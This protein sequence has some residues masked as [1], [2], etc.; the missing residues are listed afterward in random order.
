M[1]RIGS[2]RQR[3]AASILFFSLVPIFTVNQYRF[4]IGNHS[5]VVP[6][7]QTMLDPGLFPGDYL[8]AERGHL[9]TYFWPA[10]AFLIGHLQVS[11][12][13]L[14][15]AL[16]CAATVGAV[17]GVHR[18]AMRLFGR[19]DVAALSMFFFM[20]SFP[21]LG[22]RS[23]F[24][25][26]LD[27]VLVACPF[28]LFA[29][30]AMLARRHV[31]AFGLLGVAFLI[32]PLSAIY[33]TGVV[34]AASI[35]DLRTVGLARLAAALGLMTV[36]MLPSLVWRASGA[37]TSLHLLHAD[38]SWLDLLRLRSPYHIFPSTW[39]VGQF[40]GAALLV[41][42]FVIGWK[43]RPDAR[44]HRLVAAATLG[45]FAMWTAGTVFVEMLP[46]AIVVQAQL[47]RSS[48]L[49]LTLA[50]IYCANFFFR[51]LEGDASAWRR[52]LAAVPAVGVLYGARGGLVA[53]A[54]LIGFAAAVTFL[55][56]RRGVRVEAGRTVPLLMVLSLGLGVGAYG[57]SGGF[58]IYDADTPAWVDVQH[59]ARTHSERADLFIVPVQAGASGFR[60]ESERSIYVDWKDG[61]EMFWNPAFGDEWHRRMLSVGFRDGDAMDDRAWRDRFLTLDESAFRAIA[62]ATGGPDRRTM[63]VMFTE[64]APLAFPV[65][66]RNDAFVV[67]DVR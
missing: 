59:W 19:E 25:N 62:R 14:F 45:I 23:V 55:R 66:F 67:Y 3:A 39:S 61:T 5:I 32:H 38:Q 36:I 49:L 11:M 26:Y 54:G 48:D 10:V 35:A 37:P 43:Y 29:I 16:Y 65:L 33:G 46:V 7:I 42:T 1:V 53:W 17:A 58:T 12:P 30:D 27:I 24:P 63:L 4:G 50:S 51:E 47:F 20:F 8:I 52:M 21:P 57:F 28:V 40:A 15:F 6:F 9:V 60:V 34:L 2:G 56:E 31:I 64:R 22:M 41:L 13:V 18:L 44:Q